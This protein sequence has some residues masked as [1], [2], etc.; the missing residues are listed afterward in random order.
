M[1]EHQLAEILI[2]RPRGGFRISSRRLKGAHKTLDQLTQEMAEGEGF[3]PY[4]IKVRNPTKYLSENL[5]PLRRFLQ[6]KVGKNWDDT[7]SDLC[8]QI[9]S[10]TMVGQHVL[11]HLWHFVERHVEMVDDR[12]IRKPYFGRMGGP[13]YSGHWAQYYIHPESKLLLMAPRKR[14]ESSPSTS[15]LFVVI[16]KVHH[17]RLINGIWYQ[18]NF[19]FFYG[20]ESPWDQL[21]KQRLSTTL[22]YSHYGKQIYVCEKRQCNKRQIR[23][24][25]RRLARS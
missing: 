17:Y 6:A 16:D 3:S 15:S 8:R 11:Q 21:F 12:P 18:F 10:S 19:A 24:I 5:A 23:D 22:A 7:Y 14:Q 1:S 20:A 25:D 2:E 4:L 13:L 9:D